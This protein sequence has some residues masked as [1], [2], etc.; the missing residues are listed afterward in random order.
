MNKYLLRIDLIA[1]IVIF[2]SSVLFSTPF[3]DQ[4]FEISGAD[5]LLTNAES[6]YNLTSG[7]NGLSLVLEESEIEGYI[8]LNSHTFEHSF[9]LA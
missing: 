4:F 6:I 2:K 8:I 5:S 7:S 9:I 3:P 1:I